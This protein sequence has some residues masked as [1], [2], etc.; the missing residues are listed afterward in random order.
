MFLFSSIAVTQANMG[1]DAYY[2]FVIEDHIHADITT[3]NKHFCILLLIFKQNDH[4]FPTTYWETLS[5][6]LANAF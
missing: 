2:Q 6:F 3:V 4:L 5:F 1:L